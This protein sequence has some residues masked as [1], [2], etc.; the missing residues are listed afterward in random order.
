MVALSTP[1]IRDY[2]ALLERLFVIELL[3]PWH[4]NRAKRLVKMPKPHLGD[5]GVASA[6][7]GATPEVLRQ[8][9]ELLGALLETFVY[10]ELRRQA[11]WNDADLRFFHFR[12]RD[13][14]EVDIVIEHGAVGLAGIEIKAAATV[15]ESDFRGLRKLHKAAGDRFVCGA[16]LYDGETSAGFGDKMRAIP[17]RR[18]WE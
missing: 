13:G 11:S 12:D 6:L 8:N 14:A 2:L 4:S 9:R 10:G 5:T 7:L 15:T 3:P 1:A 18:L 16:V 17:I